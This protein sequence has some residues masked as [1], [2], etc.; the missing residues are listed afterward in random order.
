MSQFNINDT[1]LKQLEEHMKNFAG[2]V[3]EVINDVLHNEAAPLAQDAIRR[4]MPV[5]GK[6]WKGKKAAAK[7]GK[8]M[9]SVNYNLAVEVKTTK[10]YQY[11]YFPN[12]GTNTRRHAGQQFFFEKGGE[13]VQN[14]VVERC[15]ARLTENF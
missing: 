1:G 11:L 12:D 6:S 15:V 2:N 9:Q 7:S 3:E 5:S 4:L 8:S 10:D 13:A 14:D